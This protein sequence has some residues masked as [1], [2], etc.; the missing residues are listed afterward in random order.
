MD[1]RLARRLGPV[2]APTAILER[3][4]QVVIVSLQLLH[5][6]HCLLPV[7]HLLPRLDYYIDCHHNDD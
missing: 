6:L 2:G 3:F 5:S 4:S 7:V 1:A